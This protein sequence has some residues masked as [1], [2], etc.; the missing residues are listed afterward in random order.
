MR[1]PCTDL[2]LVYVFLTEPNKLPF[3]IRRLV[4]SLMLEAENID[5]I[6]KVAELVR[7]QIFSF[8]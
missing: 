4:Q 2:V 1:Y 6:Q 5:L 7:N 3:N 8:K